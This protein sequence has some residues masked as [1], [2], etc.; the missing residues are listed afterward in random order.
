M[1][2]AFSS[3]LVL[4]FKPD[5]ALRKKLYVSESMAHPAKA[6][7]GMM[8]EIIQRYSQPGDL[9]LDPMAGIG[10]TM[11]AA[12]M[13]RSVCL[14]E[15]EQHFVTPMKASWEKMR[16]HPMLGCELGQVMILRGDARALPLGRVDAV[17][18]SPPYEA[19]LGNGE[20]PLGGTPSGSFQTH[21]ADYTR[22]AAIIT[23][24]PYEAQ[25]SDEV[26]R[27][28]LYA[29]GGRKNEAVYTRPQVDAGENI[30]NLR[31]AAYWDAMR[32]VYSECHRCL[33][34]GGLLVLILKG[35]TR[36]GKYVDLP[37]QTR[38]LCETLGFSFM[39]EWQRRL[40]SLSFWR[41]LQR[42]RDPETFDDRLNYET[43]LVLRQQRAMPG[44]TRCVT[45]PMVKP[46]RKG[47]CRWSASQQL[48]MT[49]MEA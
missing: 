13:G 40:W 43:I 25:I 15:L 19:A 9:V 21:R 17:I 28:R 36:D 39:E 24:P 12:L 22:P 42:R 16:Q 6:H 2:P 34:P 35:F 10:G 27:Y 5:I 4:T 44:L 38:E 37:A 8:M 31:S 18:T 1:T 32:Q 46:C 29:G 14:I 3:P 33:R 23:S 47:E 26:N 45:C 20:G 48:A 41:I 49:G 11:I 30:G 7:L